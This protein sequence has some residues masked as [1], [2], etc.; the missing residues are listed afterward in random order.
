MDEF[1]VV[2]LDAPCSGTGTWR[3]QPELRWRLTPERLAELRATQDALLADAVSQVRPGGRLVYAT[4][5]ILPSENEDRIAAL[6]ES[7]P[8]FAI[9]RAADVWRESVGTPPP[10]NLGQFFKASP[11]STGTDGF[12]TAVLARGA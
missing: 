10:R 5:S 3:R 1:D 4:C 8:D 12:F 2:L 7:H 6:R 9:V 11:Y